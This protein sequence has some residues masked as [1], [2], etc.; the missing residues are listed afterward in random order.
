MTT[1]AGCSEAREYAHA[2]S[3]MAEMRKVGIRPNKVTF[4]AAINA[5]AMASAK[6]ARRREEED[7][8]GGVH[9]NIDVNSDDTISVLEDGEGRV[10][11]GSAMQQ[12]R[13][14][15]P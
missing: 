9:G 10:V 15:H 7:A 8:S 5:C 13:E 3:L 14:Q 12:L 11:G 1:I 6:L 2:L 4:S